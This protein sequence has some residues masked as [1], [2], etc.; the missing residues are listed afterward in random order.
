MYILKDNN[1]HNTSVPVVMHK[2][3]VDFCSDLYAADNSDDQ[4]RNQL[5]QDL[6]VLKLE[7]K[8][9]L[10]TELTFEKFTASAMRISTGRMPGLDGIPAEF[11]CFIEV[12]GMLLDMI[13]LRYSKM[14]Q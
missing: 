13:I 5:L 8:Q 2:L 6:P 3:A 4:C 14:H 7:H 11:Y 12:F 9:S 1:G 10:E